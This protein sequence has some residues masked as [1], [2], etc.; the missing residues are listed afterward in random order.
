M[1]KLIN[2]LLRKEEIKRGDG[3]VYLNRWTVFRSKKDGFFSKIG[4]GDLRLYVHQ[5]TESDHTK[6]LHDHPNAF[7]SFMFHHHGSKDII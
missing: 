1:I 2:K 4:L 5:F 3:T 7:I 6:C